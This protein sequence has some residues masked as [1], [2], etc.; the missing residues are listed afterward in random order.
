MVGVPDS[1]IIKING[2]EYRRNKC[3]LTFSPL[4]GE[5][6]DGVVDAEEQDGTENRTDRL[7]PRPALKFPNFQCK[8]CCIWTLIYKTEFEH[9]N[10]HVS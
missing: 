1:F 8:Q 10:I 6:N 9:S 5:G 4:R 3:N 2:Q 7:Q